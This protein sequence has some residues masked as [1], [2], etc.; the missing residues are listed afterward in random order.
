MQRLYWNLLRD[1]WSDLYFFEPLSDFMSRLHEDRGKDVLAVIVF[2][3][4]PENEVPP[5]RPPLWV[6]VLYKEE[7]DFLK[8][9]LF[10][11]ER[12]PSGILQFF[13][14]P[15]KGFK[16]MLKDGHPI[17]YAASKTGYVIH[18]LEDCLEDIVEG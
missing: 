10:L 9:N 4:E 15:L 2:S 1:N 3:P 6:L 18:E 11:R 16:E 7:I 5:K 13:P 17:A 8:E 12:D 14:Y